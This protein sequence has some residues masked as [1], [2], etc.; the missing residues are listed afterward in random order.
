MAKT[1]P[2]KFTVFCDENSD[3]NLF[4]RLQKNSSILGSIPKANIKLLPSGNHLFDLDTVVSDLANYDRP[5]F[6]VVYNRTPVAVLELTEHGY[7]GDNPLQRFTRFATT[8]ENKI[9]FVYFT[10]FSRVR[11]DELDLQGAVASKRS[12]NTNVWAGMLKLAE[13]YSVPQIALDWPLAI[14]GKPKKLSQDSDPSEVS[15][16]FG[17]LITAI[18]FFVVN[19]Q[20]VANKNNIMELEYIKAHIEKIRILASTPNVRPTVVKSEWTKAKFLSFLN[21]PASIFDYITPAN[22]FYKDKPERLLAMTCVENVRFEQLNDKS[23]KLDSIV[24][25]LSKVLERDNFE[26]PFIY[27]TGYKWRFLT[28]IVES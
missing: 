20:D 25:K 27:Y 16:V 19:A 1:D 11:D 3:R 8:A 22:Y 28:H 2:N 21:K 18:E 7:T 14:N 5:D 10:P 24:D 15:G 4:F 17:E 23:I 12:V 26:N 6:I 13:I 9:P